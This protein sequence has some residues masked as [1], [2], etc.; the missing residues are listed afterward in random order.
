MLL[1]YHSQALSEVDQ[2]TEDKPLANYALEQTAKNIFKEVRCTVC[3][4]Q[5]I[6]DSNA[7]IAR[8]MRQLIREKLINGQSKKAIEQFLV[9]RFGHHILNKPP[10]NQFTYLLWLGPF[11]ILLCS[12][13]YGYNY[14]KKRQPP[15]PNF[16][17]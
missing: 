12:G 3:N 9:E 8:D 15:P 1:L 7:D 5:S 13:V 11:L 10:F 4:G 6:N 2:N 16:R 14:I 17:K